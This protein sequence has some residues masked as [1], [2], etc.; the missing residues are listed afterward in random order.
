MPREFFEVTVV[1][2]SADTSAKIRKACVR[3]DQVA[4]FIDIDCQGPSD[5]AKTKITLIESD[6]YANTDDDTGGVVHG[7]RTLFVQEDYQ[8]ILSLTGVA[9]SA[10]RGVQVLSDDDAAGLLNQLAFIV[11]KKV[12]R[13]HSD[14]NALLD[15]V[16]KL[17]PHD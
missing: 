8:S 17:L 10:D 3:I 4:T 9:L 1:S 6:D 16:A 14:I 12:G 5:R 13:E 11:R 2:D 15:R 7:S